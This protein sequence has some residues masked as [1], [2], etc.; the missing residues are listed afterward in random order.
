MKLASLA[1]GSA[2]GALLVVSRDLT[3]MTPAQDIAPSLLAAVEQWANCHDALQARYQ[4]LND[5]HVPGM[6]YDPT[7]LAAPLP[8]A[9]QWCDG[10]AFLN[11]GYLM[12]QAFK[13]PAIPNVD[14]VPLMYQ[15]ASDDFLGPC[16]D[17]PLPDVAHGIDF[18]GEYGVITDDIPMACT[19]EQALRRIRLVVQINDVSLRAF[20][21]VEIRSGFGFIN[22][23]PSSSFAPVA[24]TP[25]EL[26]LAWRNG[27]VCLPLHIERNGEWFG[28]PNGQEMHFGFHEL[29]AHAARTRRLRAGTIVGSG[30]V[31]NKDRR[32]GSACIAERRA[33]EMIDQGQAVTGFLQFGESVTMQAI[34]DDGSRPFG[35]IA[36][37]FVQAL[38][39]QD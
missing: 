36:Q 19:P 1:D 27:R 26:G 9:P 17:I 31:S 28:Q 11:H 33:I 3:R 16:D 39:A 2:H 6:P 34:A 21:P 38:P 37:R 8:R 32:A 30:T 15:G 12:E 10:S 13:L 4:A 25:D 14:T 20:T 5:G 22:A 29:I 7:A 24:V 23:K 18:E 35:T